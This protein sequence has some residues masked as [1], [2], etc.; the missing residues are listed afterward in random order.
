M[1]RMGR[2]ERITN[3]LDWPFQQELLRASAHW[4]WHRHDTQA[5]TDEC[6][7]ELCR[8]VAQRH[9]IWHTRSRLARWLRSDP[10]RMWREFLLTLL[11]AVAL[12]GAALY[13]AI[14]WV[15]TRIAFALRLRRRPE[16]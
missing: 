9:P 13:I 15:T 16:L 7:A 3:W 2:M 1:E 14:E 12:V 10:L 8:R 4:C 5:E 11:S 6:R